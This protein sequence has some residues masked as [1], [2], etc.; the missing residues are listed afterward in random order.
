[1]RN[2]RSSSFNFLLQYRGYKVFG[3]ILVKF[4]QWLLATFGF[5]VIGVLAKISIL[6]MATCKEK[7]KKYTYQ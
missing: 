3:A 6:V 2:A 4:T 1:L 5:K 7:W